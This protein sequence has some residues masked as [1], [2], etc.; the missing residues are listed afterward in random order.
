MRRLIL[1]IALLSSHYIFGQTGWTHF[2]KED[3][4]ASNW[5]LTCMEDRQGNMW[6]GTDNG[7]NKFD[8]TVFKTFTK[9]EGL[10][11]GFVKN[12][13]EDKDGNIWM[14]SGKNAYNYLLKDVFYKDIGVSVLHDENIISTLNVNQKE[15]RFGM[16]TEDVD[17][18][19]WLG[20]YNAKKG[21]PFIVKNFDGK[22]WGKF[23]PEDDPA[24][25][26]FESFFID[27]SGNIWTILLSGKGEYV[28]RFDGVS[29]KSFGK[30]DG[31][32]SSKRDRAYKILFEDRN[33][34]LW[35]GASSAEIYGGLMKFNGTNW[36][37]YTRDDG[38]IG[39]SVNSIVEDHDGNI[40]VATNKGLNVFDGA[41][42]EYFSEKDK[43][44][45]NIINT[46]IVDRNGRVWVGTAKG[47]ALFDKGKWSLFN[48]KNGLAH[49]NVRIMKEDSRG[50]VWVGAASAA[51]KGGVSVYIDG[52]WVSFASDKLPNFYTHDIFEDSKGNMWIL[53]I[54]NGV[55]KYEY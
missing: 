28:Q 17:G 12:I 43:L 33:G 38:F 45:S 24:S 34:N 7:L 14:L 51:K 19:I 48:S 6:F 8:G 4:L 20:G 5:V 31:F 30:N 42:W 26:P 39:K 16:I 22:S 37:S 41:S 21:K 23:Q 9:K 50:N 25:K 2:T 3:G 55:L 44:P 36:A 40:W 46:T 18:N 11:G 53:T 1:L 35:F 52:S 54:G 47:L 13:Y 29:W 27:H 49:N 15:Y 32:P 10:P